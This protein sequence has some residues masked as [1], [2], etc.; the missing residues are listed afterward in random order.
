MQDEQRNQD[1]LIP[2]SRYMNEGVGNLPGVVAAQV[3]GH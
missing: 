1:L 3:R 2:D